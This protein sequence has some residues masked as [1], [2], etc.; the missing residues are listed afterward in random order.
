MRVLGNILTVMFLFVG[1][2]VANQDSLQAQQV[3]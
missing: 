3:N 1:L 2:G